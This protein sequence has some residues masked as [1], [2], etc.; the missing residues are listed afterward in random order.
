M[1]TTFQDVLDIIW[2][3]SNGNF[4][5]GSWGLGDTIITLIVFSILAMAVVAIIRSVRA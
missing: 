2:N 1:T 3:G 4:P 5:N